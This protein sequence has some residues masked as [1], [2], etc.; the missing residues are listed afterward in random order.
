MSDKEDIQAVEDRTG[1]VLSKTHL[2]SIEGAKQQRG[3]KWDGSDDWTGYPIFS[4]SREDGSG[5][6]IHFGKLNGEFYLA[7]LMGT[8]AREP[9]EFFIS[10]RKRER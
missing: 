7:K 8:A 2:I 4:Q 10:G 6:H 9:I 3:K 5:E 1:H